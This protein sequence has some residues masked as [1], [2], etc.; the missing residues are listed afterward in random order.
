MS[1]EQVA[2]TQ[3][4]ESTTRVRTSKKREAEL[5]HSNVS[6]LLGQIPTPRILLIFHYQSNFSICGAAANIPKELGFEKEKPCLCM[7][8]FVDE[9]TEVSAED[10]NSVYWER[11]WE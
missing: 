10:Q 7:H 9:K 5:G 6:Q 11:L 8:M 3:L 2:E 4:P 1:S